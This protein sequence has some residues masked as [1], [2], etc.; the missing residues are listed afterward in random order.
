MSLRKSAVVSLLS[1][2]VCCLCFSGAAMAKTVVKLAYENNPG[3]P[4]DVVAHKWADLVKE[5][6][7][8]EVELELYPSSQ[9]G[10]KK[11]VLEMAMM[12]VNVITI[13]DAGFLADY[14]PDFGILVGPYLAKDAKDIFKLFKTDWFKGLDEQLQQK[15]LH[16][17]TPNWMFGVRHL[18][19]TKPVEKPEDL[20]GMKIRVPNNRMQIA[21][22]KAMGATPT[23]MP[24]SEVYPGLTQGVIDG[25][26]NT[27]PVIYGQKFFEPARYLDLVG[28]M[29]MTA[30]WVGGQAFFD[31]LPPETVQLLHETGDEAGDIS[32][33]L[34]AADGKEDMAIIEKMKNEGVTVV[35]VDTT[36]FREAT[37]SVYDEFPEWTP[38]LYDKVQ[39]LLEQ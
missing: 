14:V 32:K 8:G 21:T 10:S 24:L 36:P 19:T 7:N 23:P 4:F 30:Q 12:G 25:A 2:A 29:T 20:H 3:E 38:G 26:E 15:G 1:L 27:L 31:T 16:I 5:R 39:K 35:E 34:L 17:V 37:K 22:L 13:T 6:S 18:L 11:D 28:Y 33:Q 9:L